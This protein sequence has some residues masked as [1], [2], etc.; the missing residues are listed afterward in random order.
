MIEVAIKAAEEAGKILKQNFG[1]VKTFDV[2]AD[3]TLVTEV[4][5]EAERAIVSIIREKFSRHSITAEEETKED[6]S[7]EFHWYIDPIDGTGNFKA[8][9]PFFAVSI[10]AFLNRVPLLAVVNMPITEE[11]FVAEKGKGAFLNGK[12][13]SVSKILELK[14]A[15]VH[16]AR[17]QGELVGDFLQVFDSLQEKI[18]TPRIYGSMAV[19]LAYTAAGKVDA[20]INLGAN[21]WDIAAGN[22]L[23]EEAS[24]VVTDPKGNPW[25]SETKDMVAGNE[26]LQRQIVEALNA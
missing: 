15:T 25:K 1:H 22:L 7:S 20:T 26:S 18:R 10:A 17:T 16:F 11:L 23:V 8:G 13:L 2:K 14:E 4:D 19:G 21:P 12:R 9:H 5:R 3:N 24:G 6:N